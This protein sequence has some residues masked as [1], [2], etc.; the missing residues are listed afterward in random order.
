VIET[1]DR[2]NVERFAREW[3]AMLTRV[4]VEP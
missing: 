2:A 3:E 1:F 4:E